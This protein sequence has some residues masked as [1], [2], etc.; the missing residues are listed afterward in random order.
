MFGFGKKRKRQ[1]YRYMQGMG[2]LRASDLE[3]ARLHA[4]KIYPKAEILRIFGYS[5]T[6]Y[7]NDTTIMRRGLIRE[8]GRNKYKVVNPNA[9]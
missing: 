8:V 7:L 6:T 5:P 3:T 4:N 1:E 2:S 9:R